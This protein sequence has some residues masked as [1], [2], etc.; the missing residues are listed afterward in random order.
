MNYK[1][2]NLKYI[3]LVILALAAFYI[4]QSGDVFADKIVK[5][6]GANSQS[7]VEWHGCDAALTYQNVQ[8]CP[9]ENGKFGG[10]SW[11]IFKTTNP[12]VIQE[13]PEDD[14]WPTVRRAVTGNG[15]PGNRGKVEDVCQDTK[16]QYYFAFVYDGW[17]GYRKWDDKSLVYYGPLDW[18][19]YDQKGDDGEYHHPIYHNAAWNNSHSGDDKRDHT[20]SDIKAGLRDG[21]NMN[22]WRVRGE[23][24]TSGYGR[25]E[26]ATY[27]SEAA[28]KAWRA[29][30][31]DQNATAIPKGT[32]FFCVIGESYE[33]KVELSGSANSSMNFRQSSITQN[34]EAKNCENG[35]RVTFTHTL[36]RKEGSNGSTEYE[37]TRSSSDTSVTSS[38]RIASGNSSGN[39]WTDTVDMKAGMSVCETLSFKPYPDDSKKA[40]IKVCAKATGS[41]GNADLDMNVRNDDVTKY[42]DYQKVIYVKPGDKI[43][44][45]G[46]YSS[47][48]PLAYDSLNIPEKVRSG[49]NLCPPDWETIN[50]TNIL[51]V[52]FNSCTP[53][54]E[55]AFSMVIDNKNENTRNVRGFSNTKEF[56][57]YAKN[58]ASPREEYSDRYLQEN[59]R[60]ISVYDVGGY[61][62]GV[63][64]TNNTNNVKNTPNSL[65]YTF[66][67][68]LLVANFDIN[69][70]NSN[71]A[72]AR[73]PYNFKN[74]V[75]P[76]KKDESEPVYGGEIETFDFVIHT[77]TKSNSET[78]NSGDPEYATIARDAKWK[79]IIYTENN[80]LGCDQLSEVVNDS[81][82]CA[83]TD[84]NSDSSKILSSSGTIGDLNPQG[85]KEG[86]DNNESITINIPDLVAGTRICI[87]AGAYPATSGDDTNWNNKDGDGKWAWSTPK[88]YTVA[89][90]PSIQVWGGNVYSGGEINTGVST[91]NNIVNH[92]AGNPSYAPESKEDPR[93]FGS[94]GELGVI[95]NGAVIGFGSGASM[96]YAA[97]RATDPGGSTTDDFCENSPLTFANDGCS[98]KSVGSIGNNA[99]INKSEIDMQTIVSVLAANTDTTSSDAYKYSK[100]D[101]VIDGSDRID[102]S[103]VNATTRVR[104]SEKD[105]IIEKNIE[106]DRGY[107]YKELS[108][109]K[110][111]VLYAK[112]I[113]IDCSVERVDAILIAENIVKT[114]VKNGKEAP[115]LDGRDRGEKQLVVNGAIIAR[116]LEA[117]RTFGAGPGMNSIVP[118]EL[119]NFDSTLLLFG[120]NVDTLED[121]TGQ[122][123]TTS[124]YELAPRL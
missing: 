9:S 105:I 36:Q 66:E 121:N 14:D 56:N 102:A 7:G 111:A 99:S 44:Y 104:R 54:W 71:E 88:C 37:I 45:K 12:P 70:K 25:A 80:S 92:I 41:G 10:A 110:R 113:Y 106:F 112:N 119:I 75:D 74:T 73:V 117:D 18:R 103:D 62:G 78:M 33:G 63:A 108:E 49:G 28:L 1:R 79:L 86:Y 97:D 51:R 59:Q 107:N 17:Y 27:K 109:I 30:S 6:D 11:H 26:N 69:Q 46:N 76:V 13:D 93:T 4:W 34:I 50:T 19:T 40:N 124:I 85:K 91:K 32:G 5:G 39:T 60:E 90:R 53:S 123:V 64:S 48:V 84:P 3:S 2:K 55:N 47:T 77:G 82:E 16:Y 43:T 42:N 20:W 15:Y 116:K 114:C 81:M 89:K 83:D 52:Q 29:W 68:E 21:T 87:K 22:R 95:S 120:R 23:S 115:D 57:S 72:Q 118:A 58:D 101:I 98:S 31:G 67:N 122:L 61:I 96:G 65:L 38:G 94:W 24:P 35:C 8:Q 100:D